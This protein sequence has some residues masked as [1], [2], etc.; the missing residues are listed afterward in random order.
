MKIFEFE[1]KRKDYTGFCYLVRIFIAGSRKI[2]LQVKTVK[3]HHIIWLAKNGNKSAK[4]INE[5]SRKCFK[6]QSQFEDF[7]S[8]FEDISIFFSEFLAN[9]TL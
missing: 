2:I 7:L 8:F 5:M 3:T 1:F 9:C 6:K 4:K